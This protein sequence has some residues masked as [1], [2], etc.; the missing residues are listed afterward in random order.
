[1][2]DVEDIRMMPKIYLVKMLYTEII[3]FLKAFQKN[4][5]LKFLVTYVFI[6]F[7]TDF[8]LNETIDNNYLS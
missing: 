4:F 6:I 5:H 1:M 3:Y 7:I 2:S 8:Q